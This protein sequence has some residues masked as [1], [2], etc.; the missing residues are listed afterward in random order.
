LRHDFESIGTRM[1]GVGRKIEKTPKL[2]SLIGSEDW[3]VVDRLTA[4]RASD[5]SCHRA[6]ATRK[7]HHKRRRAIAGRHDCH[8]DARFAR[9]AAWSGFSYR[10]SFRVAGGTTRGGVERS[11]RRMAHE[12]KNPLT[13]IQLSAER[14]AK[15]YGRATANGN[16]ANGSTEEG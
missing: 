4:T 2:S 14:I 13:P 15:S 11:A 7:W 9:A 6:D 8:S 3:L 5:G 12:I 1:F 16:G 10:G